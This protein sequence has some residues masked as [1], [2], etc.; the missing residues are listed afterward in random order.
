MT[1]ILELLNSNDPR[2]QDDWQDI[3]AEAADTINT[4]LAALERAENFVVGFQ[5][6]EYQEGIND[7]VSAIRAA[8]AN[9]KGGAA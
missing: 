2:P 5:G 8:I 9:A 4:L 7:L 3:A 6:H 1:N